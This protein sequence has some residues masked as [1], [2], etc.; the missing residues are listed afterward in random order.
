MKRNKTRFTFNAEKV[1]LAATQPLATAYGYFQ[2][3]P[4]GLSHKEVERR[5][6]YYGKNEVEHEKRK[7]PVTM[8][9]KA[10]INPFIGILTTLIVISYVLDVWMASPAE[11]DW[12]SIIIIA[13][14]ILLSAIIRFCQD[15]K[16]SLSSEALQK[17]V[18]NTCS[19]R[20]G[21]NGLTEIPIEEL[22][23]GDIVLLAAGD[24]IPADVRIVETKDLLRQPGFAD[25]RI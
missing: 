15:W 24:M 14:M 21:E 20:R 7:N 1:F 12:T 4:C 3:A 11:K 6:S 18:K 16:A 9:I 2:T 25:R 19:V 23:P 13:T 5:Q 10:F 17:M 22:V 8:F